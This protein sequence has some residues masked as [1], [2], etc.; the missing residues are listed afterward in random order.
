MRVRKSANSPE[1]RRYSFSPNH[2]TVFGEHIHNG[3]QALLAREDVLAVAEVDEGLVGRADENS[4]LAEAGERLRGCK[5]PE[6]EKGGG[7]GGG[8]GLMR[9]VG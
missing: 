2:D 8:G 7:G 3:G 5:F 4:P 9:W 6:R 1:R